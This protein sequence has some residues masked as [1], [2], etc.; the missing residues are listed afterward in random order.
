MKNKT[1]DFWKGVSM[2]YFPAFITLFLTVSSILN[3]EN[4]E[5]IGAILVAINTFLG[6]ILGV[7]STFY[8]NK[9]GDNK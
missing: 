1:Y 7:S 3:W 8:N 5:T 6:S 4:G 2:I 9:G